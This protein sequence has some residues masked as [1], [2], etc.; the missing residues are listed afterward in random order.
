LFIEF[1]T[2]IGHFK[3]AR[4]SGLARIVLILLC[5]TE[6]KQNY[7]ELLLPGNNSFL[8][9]DVKAFIMVNLNGSNTRG[10]IGVRHAFDAISMLSNV[11]YRYPR[12][13]SDSTFQVFVTGGYN[14]TLV[15][16]HPID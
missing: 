8:T 6:T 2:I 12:N 13:L 9:V 4:V 11:H 14:V 10:S 5:H 7:I 15:L 3:H 16:G 1:P